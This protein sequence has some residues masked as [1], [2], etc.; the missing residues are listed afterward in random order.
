VPRRP[1]VIETIAIAE[2]EL[3]P[4]IN[5][6]VIS[7]P[8]IGREKELTDIANLLTNA[9]CRLLTLVGPGGTGKTRLAIQVA[10]QLIAN[11][12]SGIYFISLAPLETID[13]IIPAIARAVQFSFR[14]LSND[15]RPPED[16]LAQLVCYLRQKHLLLVLDNWEHLVAGS[17]LASSLLSEVAG[18]KILATSRERLN[19]KEEWV[20]DVRGLAYPTS[21]HSQ[22][23]DHYSAIQLF[24][25]TAQRQRSGY[26]PDSTEIQCI[27]E[28][29]RAVQGMPLAIE[30]AASWI[31]TLACQEI[32]RQVS[33]NLDFLAT[34]QRDLPERHRSLRAVF[35]HSWNLLSDEER[36]IY[37]RLSVF[38]GGF[39]LDA[40]ADVAQSP[41]PA[42]AALVDKSLLNRTSTGRYE[43]HEMLKQFVTQHLV[44]NKEEYRKTR[45]RH[46]DYFNKWLVHYWRALTGAGQRKAID[47]IQVEFE[48]LR[49]AWDWGI[50]CQ[51]W[52]RMIPFSR[53]MFL[54][55]DISGKMSYGIEDFRNGLK[56]VRMLAPVYP[57]DK[58]LQYF[59]AILLGYNRTHL[60]TMDWYEKALELEREMYQLIKDLPPSSERAFALLLINFGRETQPLEEALAN[61]QSSERI[62]EQNEDVFSRA[63]ALGDWAGMVYYGT[64]GGSDEA[65]ILFEKALQILKASGDFWATTITL[66]GLARVRN[67]RGEYERSRELLLEALKIYQEIGDEWRA[68]D[69]NFSLGQ[70][71]TWTGDY[72]KAREY[73]KNNLDFVQRMGYPIY[74]ASNLDCLGYIE[75]LSRNYD[76]ALRYY[77]ESLT[78]YQKAEEDRGIA[79][80]YNNLGDI[81]KAQGDYHLAR[82]YF[83]DANRLLTD[84]MDIWIRSIIIKNLGKIRFIFH[85]YS[86]A[87]FYLRKALNLS[88]RIDR[89]PDILDVYVTLAQI[90]ALRGQV[91]KALRVLALVRVHYAT[92]ADLRVEAENQFLRLATQL[93][94]EMVDRLRREG[95]RLDIS[96][97]LVEDARQDKVERRYKDSGWLV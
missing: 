49:K 43:L 35:D 41:F 24:I 31:R 33:L 3:Q 73:F 56:K 28:I 30:L 6:P 38:Q 51:E 66:N 19:L 77:Q 68:V 58:E 45:D 76:E 92:T 52:G 8:F 13:A 29:C 61:V 1:A 95:E 69:V 37:T 94:E 21:S 53:V 96:T 4:T 7:T 25:Q 91:E 16:A 74:Y 54:F 47:E 32:A 71:A 2:P 55:M 20:Y 39:T 59:F 89:I 79:I 42:L 88:R 12:E 83:E 11:F 93:E 36:A 44:E 22:Y 9:E 27:A 62:F 18:I 48:N 78:I 17:N 46:F 5:L 80:T 70:N 40:A 86:Q 75:F 87:E 82:R 97:V 72:D 10:S 90:Q 34:T 23:L 15:P 65:V 84:D 60:M 50:Q 64:P 63:L 14:T 67:N 85:E 26:Q 81:A 57:E